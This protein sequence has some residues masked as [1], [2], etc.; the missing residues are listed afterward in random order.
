MGNYNIFR[1]YIL[2][3]MEKKLI[4]LLLLVILNANEIYIDSSSNS[5][6]ADGTIEKPLNNIDI[7]QQTISNADSNMFIIQ[8]ILFL[9]ESLTIKNGRF[10]FRFILL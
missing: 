2:N 4:L 3:K 1:L 8:N 6:N 5:S 7:I 10:N 9:N